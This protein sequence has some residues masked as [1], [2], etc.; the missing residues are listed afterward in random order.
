MDVEQ[1]I[2]QGYKERCQTII[3]LTNVELIFVTLDLLDVVYKIQN[4]LDLYKKRLE[5][6]EPP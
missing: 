1:L 4:L 3:P 2:K 5:E 6:L